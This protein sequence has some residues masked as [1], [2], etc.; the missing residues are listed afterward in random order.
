MTTNVFKDSLRVRQIENNCRLATRA[1]VFKTVVFVFITL[2][3]KTGFS[4]QELQLVFIYR[5]RQYDAYPSCCDRENHC[6]RQPWVWREGGL[7]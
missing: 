7:E 1:S 6:S 4:C 2:D 5:D 3:Y